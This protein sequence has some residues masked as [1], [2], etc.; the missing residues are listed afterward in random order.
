MP[1][2]YYVKLSISLRNDVYEKLLKV[3]E[4]TGLSKSGAVA[5]LVQQADLAQMDKLP[6]EKAQSTK[7]SPE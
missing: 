5:F 1:D 3:M 7:E 2:T 6:S 4:M